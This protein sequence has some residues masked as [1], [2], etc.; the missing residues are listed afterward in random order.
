MCGATYSPGELQNPVSQYSGATPVTKKSTHYF[1]RVSDLQ[2]FLETWINSPDRLDRATKNKVLEWIK[3][4]RK[5]KDWAISRDG[6]YFGFEI[7]D[8][9]D[10]Y[11]YVWLD[12]P[13]GYMAATKQFCDKKKKD[14]SAIWRDRNPTPEYELYHFIGKDIANFHCIFWPALLSAAGFRTPDAVFVHGFLTVNGKKMSKR[15][16]TLITL[17]EYLKHLP[18]RLCDTTMP[19]SLALVQRTST[20]TWM[21]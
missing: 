16:G 6:P 1:F 7:P 21:T 12:A 8:V 20:S 15:E 3:G 10:K 2:G 11:F 17:D 9:R 5:L 18:P 19:P 14:F 13:I 4:D